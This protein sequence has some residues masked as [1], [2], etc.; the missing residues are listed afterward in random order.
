M[1]QLET[2][3]QRRVKK[4]IE[5]HQLKELSICERIITMVHDHITLCEPITKEWLVAPDAV[6]VM[7][8][9]VVYKPPIKD[10]EYC[11]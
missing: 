4:I 6:A 11:G 5:K 1:L 9:H 8:S 2:D 10:P 7:E 3:I